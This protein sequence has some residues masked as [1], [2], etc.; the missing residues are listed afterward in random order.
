MENWKIKIVDVGYK[1]ER[2]I[3]IFRKNGNKVE[4]YDG[5]VSD[6]DGAIPAKPTLSLSPESLQELANVLDKQGF[7]PKEG[8]V[9]GK[10]Q[11]T[12]KHL[13]DMRKLVFTSLTP[14]EIK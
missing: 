3:Y 7:S 4:M 12:E 6:I 8:F 10:L 13:E 5:S 11:A 2:D 1:F 14:K 9:E